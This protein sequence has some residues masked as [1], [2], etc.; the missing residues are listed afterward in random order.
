MAKRKAKAKRVRKPKPKPS[1]FG[2][3]VIKKNW[4]CTDGALV[5]GREEE[6]YQR[7]AEYWEGET[8]K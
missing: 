8:S 4:A 6:P 3:F 2:Q 1:G 5:E 7:I